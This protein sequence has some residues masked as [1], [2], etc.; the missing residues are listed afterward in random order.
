[1]AVNTIKVS[2]LI[3]A[4]FFIAGYAQAENIWFSPLTAIP[5]DPTGARSLVLGVAPY[6]YA[7]EV[8]ATEPVTEVNNKWVVL[9]LTTTA[10]KA[11]KGVQVCYEVTTDSPGSTYIA[12]V[13]LTTM[14]TPDFQTV[15]HDDPTDL[16]ST[17]PTC[18]TSNTAK[19]KPKVGGT[20]TLSLKMVFGSAS[21]K[22]TI[23]GVKLIF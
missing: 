11:I 2:I 22:I 13:R 3:F 20:T 19:R 9:G 16:T 23:G 10:N 14:T 6:G 7:L 8:T 5:E 12:Q 1:V 15:I 18:Y 17:S 4:L 21:D